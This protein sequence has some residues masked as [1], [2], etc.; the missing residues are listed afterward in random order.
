MTAVRARALPECFEL[1]CDHAPDAVAVVC[2][3]EQLDYRGLDERANR[4]ARLLRARGVATGDNVGILL[5]RCLDTYVAILGVMKA[6]AA[7]VPIDTSFPADRVGFMAEDAALT[8]LVTW[9]GGR[10][11]TADLGCPVLELDEERAAQAE[12]ASDRLDLDVDPELPAYVIYTSGSTGK[13][14]GVAISHAN[15]VNFLDVATPIYGVTAT[16]RVYQGMSISFDFH[17][18]EMWPAWVGGAALVAG[19]NDARRFGQGLTEFIAEQGITVLCSVPTLLTTVENVPPSVRCLLVS[20]EAMPADLVRKWSAPG[21]RILNCYGP[22]ETTVSSSC[23]ELVA[24]EPV[25]LGKPFPTYRFYVLDE[26]LREVPDGETGEI[27]IGGPSVGIGYLNRPDLNAERFIVNPVERDRA[28]APRVYRTGDLGRRTP[29]GE[30]E[31]FGRMDTQVKIRG[32]RVELGEIEQVLRE[33]HEVE[34]AVV[35]TLDRDGVPHLVAY[36]TLI[37]QPPGLFDDGADQADGELRDRLHSTLRRRLAPYMVPNYIEVLES[38]PLLAADKVNR[39][40]LPAPVSPPLGA[41]SGPHVPPRGALETSVAEVWARVLEMDKVSVEADFFCDLGGHSLSAARVISKLREV[42]E[43]RGL[44][45]GDIYGNPT[46]RTLAAYVETTAAAAPDPADSVAAIERPAPL[47]HSGFRVW[48]C[49]LAQLVLLYGWML[50]L[51]TPTLALTYIVTAKVGSQAIGTSLLGSSANLGVLI[52]IWLVWFVITTFGLPIIGGRL[53][54]LGVRPGFHPLWGSTYLRFW[55]YERVAALAPLR[56][57]AGTPLL[58][59]YLRLMGATVGRDCQLSSAQVNLPRFVTIGSGVSMGDNS[60]IEPFT[61]EEGWL[62][63]APVHVGDGAF[64]GASSGVLAGAEVGANASIGDQSLVHTDMRVPA[65]EHWLGSPLRRQAKAPQLLATMAE[66]AEDGRWRLSVLLGYLGG[67]VLLMLL[68]TIL[69]VPS[70]ALMVYAFAQGGLVWAVGSMVASGPVF[71][72][73][74][75]LVLVV[76]KRLVLFRARPG[77]HSDRGFFGVR[78]WVSNRLLEMSVAQVRTIYCTLYAIPFLRGLGLRVGKWCEIA[79]PTLLDVDMTTMGD[80]CFLAGGIIVSPPV[81]HRGRVALRMAEL[82]D[83]SFIGNVALVPGGTRMGSN[84]LLGVMSV[85]P[86]DRPMDPE[87]T[88]LGSPSFFLPRRETS[89]N[90]PEKMTYLPTRGMVAGRL[91]VELFRVFLPAM[92]ITA[93]TF[94]S[95]YAMVG[96]LARFTLPVVAVL[97]PAL[98]LAIGFAQTLVVVLLKWLIMGRYRPRTEPYWST[99]VRGTELITGLYEAVVVPTFVGNLVGTPWIA[100]VMRLLGLRIGRRVWLNTVSFTEFDLSRIGDDA[101]VGQEADLQTHLF[102]DRVMKMSYSTASARSTIGSH[103]VVLYDAEVS[104]DTFL[105]ADSLAMKG[106]VLPDSTGWRGI[107]ARPL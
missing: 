50:L 65:G 53:V 29:A 44:A 22:T 94:L 2:E 86:A 85:P 1:S 69:L 67:L 61:V 47:R 15:I 73:F 106:E 83:R 36:L 107:P 21:R 52:P 77:I 60:R 103:A 42:P 18:E 71:V 40:A 5:P 92:L 66:G 84:S 96:L 63:I 82:S 72:V 102:E 105:D 97:L 87:T 7:Y 43:L 3:G 64:I 89:Q 74:T 76:F 35:T 28:E 41:S 31:F 9:S 38:F 13:P 14:K 24:D 8:H 30:Y 46:I 19:P 68:P 62:R 104:A 34:N 93:G 58:P 95:F 91:F 98:T 101:M 45:M 33:D 81:H 51:A 70:G 6:G 26:R 99:W 59:M 23:A 32:Y 54:L 16:D 79:V 48:R 39:K 27:C 12:Q 56:L 4:L 25:T 90:F 100:P 80:Q 78:L 20:G 10:D 57:L 17:L 11:R 37:P 49:G 88:W 75:C 55:F